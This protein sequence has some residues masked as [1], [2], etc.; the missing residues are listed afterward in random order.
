MG[1]MCS[2]CER[3]MSAE[4]GS[5]FV[6]T[7]SILRPSA[8]SNLSEL[9]TGRFRQFN[10]LISCRQRR[11][12]GVSK[13]RAFDETLPRG[14]VRDR[15]PNRNRPV[16]LS[17]KTVYHTAVYGSQKEDSSTQP[18]PGWKCGRNH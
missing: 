18:G 15:N 10:P 2:S 1:L 16:L 8:L 13:K 11:L 4:L 9:V 3:S 5:V 12:Q 17:H 7:R 6:I 14:P